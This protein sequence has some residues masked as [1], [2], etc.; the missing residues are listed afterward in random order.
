[1]T[2]RA[3]GVSDILACD[4]RNVTQDDCVYS[5]TL[6]YISGRLD[7][8]ACRNPCREKLYKYYPTKSR[9]PSEAEAETFVSEHSDVIMLSANFSSDPEF[10]RKNFLMLDVFFETLQ[11]RRLKEVPKYKVSLTLWLSY[12]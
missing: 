4:A 12:E 9:W 8:A 1:M 5:V 6:D 3:L 11:Q 10:Y 2:G 7:C